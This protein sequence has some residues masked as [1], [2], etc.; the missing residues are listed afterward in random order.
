M[1]HLHSRGKEGMQAALEGKA[2][3]DAAIP[4]PLL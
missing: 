1:Q 3:A 2:Q 4:S